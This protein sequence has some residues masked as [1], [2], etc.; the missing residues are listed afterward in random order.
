MDRTLAK[1]SVRPATSRD[2]KVHR[3]AAAVSAVALAHLAALG[4]CKQRTYNDKG[5]TKEFEDLK[6]DE[7]KELDA[8]GL[9]LPRLSKALG[10]PIR[11]AL[12]KFKAVK[13]ILQTSTPEERQRTTVRVWLDVLTKE[14]C[15]AIKATLADGWAPGSTAVDCA[16]DAGTKPFALEDFLTP[17]MQ[18]TL[19]KTFHVETSETFRELTPDEEKKWKVS[20]GGMITTTELST[21]CWSTAYEVQRRQRG[22]SPNYTVHNLLPNE[23]DAFMSNDANTRSRGKGMNG[24]QLTEWIGKYGADF[25]DLLIVRQDADDDGKPDLVHVATFLD[26]DLLFER[27]G[28]DGGFPTRL[29]TLKD[30]VVLYPKATF[31]VRRLDATAKD[32]P[33]PKDAKFTLKFEEAAEGSVYNT[34]IFLKDLKL[35][36]AANGRFQLPPEAKQKSIGE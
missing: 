9:A 25:G 16:R 14:Q 8:D 34:T 22:A 30:N 35:V 36:R 32:F 12:P 24:A 7:T 29:A 13:R 27:V 33:H 10:G 4:G 20:G 1:A 2:G 15:E 3:V 31:E 19:Y 11:T 18:A 5:K 23:V 28:T 6:V 26:H 21:N 17:V